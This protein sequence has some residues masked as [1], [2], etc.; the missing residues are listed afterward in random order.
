MKRTGFIGIL[1]VWGLCAFGQNRSFDVLF[2]ALDR[3]QRD[4]AFSPEGLV[5]SGKGRALRLL[6]ASD[7]GID[8]ASPVLSRNPSY[9]AEV[10]MVIRPVKPLRFLDI[11]NALGNIQGLKG[12]AYHSFSRNQ[13][14]PLFEDAT[15]IQSEKKYTPLPDPVP[16]SSVPSSETVYVRLK[17]ANFGNC[18][19]RADLINGKGSLLY[20][21]SNFKHLTY[22]FVTVI[23]ENKFVAQLYFEFVAQGLMIY[24]IA[25]ADVSDFVAS[26]ID[27]PSA[28]QKR[29]EVIIQWVVEG[30]G[31]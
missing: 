6:P 25:G 21:F 31:S 14:I 22:L 27:I 13:R 24:S 23:K 18:Y 2:P 17:D 26:Q 16:A 8:I 20:S 4:Q 9:L 12:R 3:S 29:L 10:L 15:R 11:Y 1:L 5:I 19:Y 7:S 30:L 28:I